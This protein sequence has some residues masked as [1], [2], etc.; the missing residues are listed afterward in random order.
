MTKT[1]QKEKE[2]LDN[3]KQIIKIRKTTINHYFLSFVIG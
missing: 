1:G 2:E 3:T